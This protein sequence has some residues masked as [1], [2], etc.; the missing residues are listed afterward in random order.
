MGVS[1]DGILCYGFCLPEEEEITWLRAENVEADEESEDSEGEQMDFEDF[2]AKLEGLKEPDVPFN[3]GK[4]PKEWEKYWDKK[5][6]LVKKVGIDLVTH[7]SDEYPMY[8]LA[9]SESVHNASRGYPE[10]LGQKILAN[11]GLP[12]YGI[13]GWRD[14]LKAFCE[15]AGIEYK[16]PQWIL[17]SMW[18]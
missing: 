2:V 9:I 10:K 16:D 15:R 14:K 5:S 6:K 12:A 13:E 1:T 18:S 3:S 4:V 17:C 11:A 7:C 8:I